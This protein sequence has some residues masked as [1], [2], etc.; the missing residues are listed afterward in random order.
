MFDEIE[1]YYVI[2]EHFFS[3]YHSQSNY[4]TCTT[5]AIYFRVKREH[6]W[7]VLSRVSKG[8]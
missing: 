4:R 1:I 7:D 2:L 8:A 3:K 5:N 6:A